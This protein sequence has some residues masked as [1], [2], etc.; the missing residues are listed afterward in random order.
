MSAPRLPYRP[1]RRP[2]GASAELRSFAA[3]RVSSYDGTHWLWIGGDPEFVGSIDPDF[4]S[5]IPAVRV[6]IG[7]SRGGI[8]KFGAVES[9]RSLLRSWPGL[10]FLP[11]V[12]ARLLPWNFHISTMRGTTTTG[13]IQEL[14]DT[15]YTPPECRYRAPR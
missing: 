5:P 4:N 6:K 12:G 3:N 2:R 10:F 11:T 1:C 8:E 9:V 14:Q 7:D 15:L 13:F